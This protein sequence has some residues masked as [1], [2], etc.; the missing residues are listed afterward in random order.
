MLQ[1]SNTNKTESKIFSRQSVAEQVLSQMEFFRIT[2]SNNVIL[3]QKLQM[4][5]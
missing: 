4:L 1:V 2:M 5:L 3:E